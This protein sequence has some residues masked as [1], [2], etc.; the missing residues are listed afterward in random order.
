MGVCQPFS[1]CRKK[2]FREIALV[3]EEAAN[4]RGH[5]HEIRVFT[6]NTLTVTL[7]GDGFILHFLERVVRRPLL[8]NSLVKGRLLHLTAC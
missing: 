1:L 6:A 8:E 5:L 3:F 4:R 7:H 2:T